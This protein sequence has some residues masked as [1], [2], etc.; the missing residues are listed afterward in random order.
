MLATKVSQVYVSWGRSKSIMLNTS[1]L[2]VSNND[3][4]FV[5]GPPEKRYILLQ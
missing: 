1:T 2:H 3:D 5:L 4:P